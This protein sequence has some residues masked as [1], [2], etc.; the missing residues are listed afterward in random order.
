MRVAVPGR[1][2]LDNAGLAVVFGAGDG[3]R[4]HGIIIAA[5]M[6]PCGSPGIY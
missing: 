1:L 6:I 4:L 5:I 3:G 2:I